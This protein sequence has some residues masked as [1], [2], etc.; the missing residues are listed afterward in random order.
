V[1]SEIGPEVQTLPQQ[2]ELPVAAESPAPEQGVP[3]V[4]EELAPAEQV[5]TEPA[6]EDTAG[7]LLG[8]AAAAAAGYAALPST[9]G[10]RAEEVLPEA[11][12]PEQEGAAISAPAEP[13]EVAAPV[14]E[15]DNGSLAAWMQQE[16]PV[17]L[18]S[19]EE[20]EGEEEVI[21]FKPEKAPLESLPPSEIPAWLEPLAPEGAARP[22]ELGT[23]FT[24]PGKP[25]PE[26]AGLERAEI[27]AW[28]E[29]LRP[30]RKLEAEQVTEEPVEAGG[31]LDGMRGVLRMVEDVDPTPG[32]QTRPVSTPVS[33]TAAH[34]EM[35]TRLLGEPTSSLAKPRA[36]PTAAKPS[37]GLPWLA[38]L[39]LLAAILLPVFVP[40]LVPGGGSAPASSAAADLATQI[41]GLQQGDTV[42][43]SIDY[44]PGAST[45]LDWPVRMVVA[46]LK[47]KGVNLLVTSL[48][49]TGP[50]LAARFD[51][52]GMQTI[53]LGYL[54]GQEMGLQR[55][56]TGLEGVFSVDFQGNPVPQSPFGIR[57]LNDVSLIITAASSQDTVRWWVEQVRTQ[58]SAPMVAVISGAIEPGVRPY[59]ASGQ[60]A[61][62][63]SG[64]VGGQA[65]RQAA[66]PAETASRQDVAAMEAQSL[67]HLVIA[68]LIVLGNF[69]YWGKR[70]FGRQ[71]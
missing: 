6:A 31:I 64:W 36:I 44:D 40:G 18:E 60:L 23:A 1:A 54:P 10:E 12:P 61:G 15:A 58:V 24:P 29:A 69:A 68:L 46:D 19:D 56:A 28:I 20:D 25:S 66:T 53:L 55:L 38:F 42:L 14:S 22:E 62:L 47:A 51:T 52:S 37:R 35:L 71:P 26:E 32:Q 39:L 9:E 41:Q 4:P 5:A 2:E 45:E 13:V 30:G 34:A 3:E 59:Y 7:V 43:L 8:A 50:G 48:T 70:L 57:S 33:V 21:V 11:A 67:A 65:Y 27:P 16:G 63:V 17:I 49:P